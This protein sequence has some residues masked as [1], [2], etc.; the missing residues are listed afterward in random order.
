MSGSRG[1][2]AHFGALALLL[3]AA[4][5]Q[6]LLV[7][8][9]HHAPF[10]ADQLALHRQVLAGTAQ[11]PYQYQMYFIER[12]LE[13]LF[14]LAPA[15]D[16]AGFARLYQW[17]YGL[18]LAL[19]LILLFRLCR[20]LVPPAAATLAVLYFIAILPIFWYDNYYHPSDPWGAALA[21]V[22]IG[23]IL[24]RR[25]WRALL[26][27]LLASSLLWEKALLIPIAL[28]LGQWLAGERRPF[29]V[30]RN[31]LVTGLL[32]FCAVAGQLYS[33]WLC[34][35]SVG[36][37]DGVDLSTNLGQIPLYLAGMLVVFGPSLAG[38]VRHFRQIPPPL[39]ALA[40]QIPLFI[41]IYL[42][43]GG[44][45]AEMRGLLVLVPAL[46]PALALLAAGRQKTD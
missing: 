22:L 40:W 2:A 25:H 38:F 37:W 45:L 16:A 3:A 17:S 30:I 8:V 33:R 4:L 15:R 36:S 1:R 9:P 7:H 14:R 29:R 42:A 12:P 44:V 32:C 19:F 10:V 26:L 43:M 11:S 34:R 31:G 5:V 20:R 24:D 13:W 27:P 18:G 41:P 6:T 28:F 21:V 23:R 35:A 46:W 39:R